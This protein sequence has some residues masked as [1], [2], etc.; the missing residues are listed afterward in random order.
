M[1]TTV[2]TLSLYGGIAAAAVVLLRLIPRL[3]PNVKFLLWCLVFLRLILPLDLV[4]IPSAVSLQ[5]VVPAS[6]I[7][8]ALPARAA[9]TTAET[10]VEG[11]RP[12]PATSSVPAVPKAAAGFDW[13]GLLED[14]WLAGMATCALLMVFFYARASFK[15]KHETSVKGVY[16]SDHVLTPVVMGIFRP[17]IVLPASV[18]PEAAANILLHE[19][20]HIKRGDHIAKPLFLLIAAVHWFNPLVWLAYR[21]AVRDMEMAVDEAVLRASS[22]D[23]RKAYATELLNAA[24]G[25]AAVFPGFGE[26]DVKRRIKSILNFK[27]PSRWIAAASVLL[28]IAAAVFLLAG[29]EKAVTAKPLYAYKSEYVGDNSNTVGLLTSLPYGAALQKTE[30]RTDAQPYGIVATY[31][32]SYFNSIPEDY[33]AVWED[34]AATVFA[35]IGNVDEIYFNSGMNTYYAAYRAD[36]EAKFKQDMRLFSKD[37]A[38]FAA[39]LAELEGASEPS[40]SAPPTLQPS[41]VSA[42]AVPASLTLGANDILS[43]FTMG[44]VEGCKDLE[45]GFFSASFLYGPLDSA[46]EPFAGDIF[47]QAYYADEGYGQFSGNHTER[48]G[49]YE[50]V[51]VN[52]KNGGTWVDGLEKIVL[53][54]FRTEVAHPQ[55][56]FIAWDRTTYHLIFREPI[57]SYNGLGDEIFY[58]DC[59]VLDFVTA[60]YDES[61]NVTPVLTEKQIRSMV[62]T[63]ALKAEKPYKPKKS[64]VEMAEM[65]E[66]KIIDALL[67]AR[68]SEAKAM[69]ISMGKPETILPDSLPS[70]GSC[71]YGAV[72]ENGIR[73][74]VYWFKRDGMELTVRIGMDTG[75]F[76]GLSS[77]VSQTPAPTPKQ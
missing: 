10:P 69:Y 62:E 17:K 22:A 39:F 13:M 51:V 23:I 28:V 54:H 73:V 26:S 12:E 42:A 68:T 38:A 61:G 74:F 36:F 21:L 6:S 3:T 34:N 37:E 49:E 16:M 20:T 64:F 75:E 40:P 57:H 18:N 46:S 76:L 48:V 63:F 4:T 29:G 45:S 30:L 5:T 72:A 60:C 33:E 2:L 56:G 32:F 47:Q 35:L 8:E 70:F 11:N 67:N 1:L 27:K 44:L 9:E 59:Y 25:G 55:N 24:Q 7:A 58:Q 19:R 41:A 50:E 66:T 52:F 15:K 31:D 53:A 71:S 65:A 77:N 14:V 43:D